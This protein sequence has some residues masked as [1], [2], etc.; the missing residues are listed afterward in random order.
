MIKVKCLL[1]LLLVLSLPVVASG[2][3][4][5][6]VGSA[7][8]KTSGELL[9]REYHFCKEQSL[10]C[11]VKYI[12]GSGELIARK[13]LDYSSGLTSPSLVMHDYRRSVEL[14]YV[15]RENEDLVV[16]AGFDN[17]VRS[18]WEDLAKGKT[19]TFPFLVAGFERPLK[20]RAQLDDA[21][22]CE[23][24]DM[25]LEINVDSWFLGLLTDPI[26]LSYS[27]DSRR[28]LRFQGI[29]NI[30]AE[31]GGSLMV[32]IRYQYGD[33]I[34]LVGPLPQQTNSRFNL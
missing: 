16:D 7:Y 29:S 9:Y 28:L 18:K 25:C 3:K 8:D 19:I 11:S 6:V 1:G 34:V 31:D 17:F 14:S 15:S 22:S 23:S 10:Q 5:Q 26:A 13:E 4:A 12:D 24:K 32:D 30:R 21:P 20:M 27:R 33:D 2:Q